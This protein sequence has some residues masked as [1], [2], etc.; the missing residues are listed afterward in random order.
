MTSLS[1]G[2]VLLAALLAVACAPLTGSPATP[3]SRDAIG[4]R[5]ARMETHDGFIPLHY[6]AGT[7]KVFLTVEPTGEDFLYL[8][9]LA[10]G[11][12]TTGPLLDRGQVGTEAVVRF[13]RRGARMLLVRQNTGFR[14][15]GGHEALQRSVEES[16]PTSIIASFPIETSAGGRHL[17]DATD[18]FLSDAFD[19]GRIHPARRPG[20]GAAGP[21]PE[22]H[23]RGAFRRLP[24]QHRG[25]GGPHPRLRRPRL[26]TAPARPGRACHHP[27]AAALLRG[28]PRAGVRAAR[29]RPAHGDLLRQLPGLRAA[30]ERGAAPAPHR[31]LAAGEGGPRRRA[32]GAGGADPLLPGPRRAG[33]VPHRLHRGGGVVERDLRGGRLPRRLPG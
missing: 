23:R 7:G 5:T 3:E 8:N 4:E 29:L 10:T 11:L 9:T 24:P 2:G 20:H 16:F 31:P 19:V 17:V 14:A 6:D 28:A 30:A 18:F 26:G 1:R 32:V 22:L 12:G 33:A 15:E 21:G 27:A 13:E 25:A